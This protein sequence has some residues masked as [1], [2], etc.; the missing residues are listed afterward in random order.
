LPAALSTTAQAVETRTL[1]FA[2]KGTT[3]SGIPD[4][5]PEPFS[6][7]LIINF[8]AGIGSRLW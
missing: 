6:M 2:C 3:V 1:T 5:K 4:A 7:S 8:T